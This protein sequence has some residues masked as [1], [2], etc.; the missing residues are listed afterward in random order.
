MDRWSMSTVIKPVCVVC[1][2]RKICDATCMSSC[3]HIS[4]SDTLTHTHTHTPAEENLTA[5]RWA[6]FKGYKDALF[7]R[8]TDSM[9]SEFS[10]CNKV[11]CVKARYSEVPSCALKSKQIV[12]SLAFIL[13]VAE[14]KAPPSLMILIL[15]AFS[16]TWNKC[17]LSRRNSWTLMPLSV[18]SLVGSSHSH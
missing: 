13:K 10:I 17:S 1:N 4:V 3:N 12:L 7:P 5:Q 16:L 8:N 14:F 11:T 9:W 18:F 15:K 6:S 2:L